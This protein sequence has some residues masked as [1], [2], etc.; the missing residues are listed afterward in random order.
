LIRLQEKEQKMD[1]LT[2]MVA[3]A[4]IAYVVPKA[5]GSIGKTFTPEGGSERSLPWVQ[6]LIACFIGGA[7][8]GTVSGAIGNQGFGNWA[9]YGAAIGIMQWFALRA[10]LPVGGWWAVASTL[11]W[12]ST[13]L[14]AFTP[15]GGFFVGLV[16]GILQVIGLKVSG[17][18][19]WIVGNVVAW[20]VAGILLPMLAGPIGSAFGFILGWIIG[21][22]IIATIGALL[23]LL[24][25]SRLAPQE[26]SGN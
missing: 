15:F 23:L 21:W 1:E 10:Y 17:Q 7:F 11:G 8:G 22:G 24:P 19:W 5:L 18:G 3:G 16:I 6:W 2:K 13:P 25:L 14:F 26:I 12:A 20:G 4:V 9:V